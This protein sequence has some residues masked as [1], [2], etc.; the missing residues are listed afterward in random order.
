MVA[1]RTHVAVAAVHGVDSVL[2]WNL[3]HLANARLRPATDVA[4]R[5]AGYRPPVIA[6]LDE[7]MEPLPA[8][9]PQSPPGAG[10]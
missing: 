10:G 2:T 3:R 7:L 9:V 5:A 1:R 6:T 4:Y 8:P